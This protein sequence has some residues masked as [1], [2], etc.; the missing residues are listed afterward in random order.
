MT[1]TT[2]ASSSSAVALRPA[3]ERRTLID[4]YRKAEPGPLGRPR[5]SAELP[6]AQGQ[7]ADEGLRPDGGRQEGH[8]GAAR[9]ACCTSPTSAATIKTRPV[10]DDDRTTPRSSRAGR[11]HRSTRASSTAVDAVV[12][13]IKNA[14]QSIADALVA[15]FNFTVAQMANLA[16]ALLAAGESIFNIVKGA[17][18]R[19]GRRHARVRQEG[20]PGNRRR[21]PRDVPGLE[22]HREPRRRSAPD[23]AACDRPA[24]P[25]A[26]RAASPGWRRR[27]TRR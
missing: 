27:S 9:G 11:G 25:P 19:R 14:L 16:K 15:A 20:H 22:R 24:R 5:R 2:T 3:A 1:S 10:E 17:L 26:R 18:E 6:A 8:E 23:G 4:G 7:R 13:A 12:D 21:G